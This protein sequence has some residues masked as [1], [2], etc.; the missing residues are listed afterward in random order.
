MGWHNRTTK[1]PA[2]S[3]V[4]AD[5]A[6]T[7]GG[8]PPQGGAE[9]ALAANPTVRRALKRS[10]ARLWAA[11]EVGFG[12]A[13][14]PERII[15]V[16]ATVPGQ[17]APSS[18]SSPPAQPTVAE[19][20]AS[21]MARR[22]A[23]C[24]WSAGPVVDRSG[25]AGRR[26]V[27][28]WW[29]GSE[30]RVRCRVR[31]FPTPAL[32]PQRALLLS[33][34]AH[35]RGRRLR[36]RWLGRRAASSR[37]A[38]SRLRLL[39]VRWCWFVVGFAGGGSGAGGSMPRRW[40]PIPALRPQ[41]ALWLGCRAVD[42]NRSRQA[43]DATVSASTLNPARQW[44]SAR[45][46]KPVRGPSV[47]APPVSSASPS[48][49]MKSETIRRSP[50]DSGSDS[51]DSD[52]PSNDFDIDALTD[53]I[54]RR[55]Q[56]RLRLGFDRRGASGEVG[57]HGRGKGVSRTW[58]RKADSVP[59]QP[60]GVFKSP[61]R[62]TGRL[63]PFQAARPRNS[64]CRRRI[65]N[66]AV[67]RSRHH[68]RG[69]N[70]HEVHW[71]V[72]RSDEARSETAWLRQEE[73]AR[74]TTMGPVSLGR[75]PF[76]H[77]VVESLDL[78]FGLLR[79]NG[80]PLRAR[81][82][83]S[84]KQY[85]PDEN[86]AAN[87]TSTPEPERLHQVQRGETLDRLLPP[88]TASR[89]IGAILRPPTAFLI[90]LRSR[91]A[92]FSLFRSWSHHE[93]GQLLGA[94]RRQ[95]V[96]KRRQ[97]WP[98]NGLAHAECGGGG[99]GPHRRVLVH[100]TGI[101]H[102][103]VG[104]A[105]PRKSLRALRN[106]P[107]CSWVRLSARGVWLRLISAAGCP[108]NGSLLRPAVRARTI[109]PRQPVARRRHRASGMATSTH[110]SLDSTQDYL[111]VAGTA[112]GVHR[113]LSSLWAVL[114]GG[115][116]GEETPCRPCRCERHIDTPQGWCRCDRRTDWCIG[117]AI[118][119]TAA[120][121]DAAEQKP[122]TDN[123]CRRSC[124]E[125]GESVLIVG[126]PVLDVKRSKIGG[127]RCR[128]TRQSGCGISHGEHWFPRKARVGWLVELMRSTALF[129]RSKRWRV[130][131]IGFLPWCRDHHR[132]RRP[133]EREL[134]DSIGDRGT[135]D[136]WATN[137]PVIGVVSNN[138]DPEK[139]DAPRWSFSSRRQ[140]RDRLGSVLTLRAGKKAGFRATPAMNDEVLVVFEQGARRPIVLGDSST[141]R[142]SQCL[143]VEGPADETR[144]QAGQGGHASH[145][146]A[147]RQ[148][149]DSTGDKRRKTDVSFVWTTKGSRSKRGREMLSW[150]QRWTSPWRQMATSHSKARTSR[151]RQRA[152]SRSMV[153][154]WMPRARRVRSSKARKSP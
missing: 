142:I 32:C 11:A 41:R 67:A 2:A 63:T 64:F 94:D 141:R 130:S 122:T 33:R 135:G 50:A 127:L 28:R 85:E 4:S 20:V 58:G 5:P 48:V 42:L 104:A 138:G 1:Q 107:R 123:T 140:F 70:C 146:G 90:P 19:S 84:L 120:G 49:S 14:T 57:G 103:E 81:A 137:G 75:Y 21:R 98:H 114:V 25:G 55:L 87:P 152:M 10:G 35:Q 24:A 134:A 118:K 145:V 23:G 61:C 133:E 124:Q 69:P 112:N 37:C 83:L 89:R 117:D 139:L 129:R 62:T 8:L 13:R 43:T 99:R 77:G 7:S 154:T 47:A 17:L 105:L 113:C 108:S 111:A 91:R 65:V 136:P 51:G 119:I 96:G 100:V 40:C 6:A 79:Q 115:H 59:F 73:E 29:I 12:A 106:R 92:T 131:S 132:T 82:N 34:S 93:C 149:A 88:T 153:W 46:L 18:V 22:A 80:T 31:C 110:W 60:V 45:Y 102:S 15:C 72:D 52:E 71:S 151:S 54:E 126:S 109:S 74:P 66:V 95:A 68:R 147:R 16:P 125:D 27:R 78:T 9:V 128:I 97:G 44:T 150:R 116:G 30:V 76:L 26:R 101:W 144:R 143:R 86:W 39:I 38:V 53:E 56:R 148:R 3:P 36:S 121:W